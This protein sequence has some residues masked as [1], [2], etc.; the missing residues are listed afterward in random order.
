M[1]DALAWDLWRDDLVE[2]RRVARRWVALGI[3]VYA[4]LALA[5]EL[6]VRDRPVG[7]VL[8]ALHVL[9]IGAVAMALA[10]LVARRSLGA[11]LGLRLPAPA[12]V[13]S[14]KGFPGTLG[15]PE[16]RCGVAL[17]RD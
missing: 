1:S 11:I 6:A 5:V 16:T 9:G 8:P 3:G 7:L 10:V 4:A 15:A 13:G 17:C 12:G 2:P 14:R